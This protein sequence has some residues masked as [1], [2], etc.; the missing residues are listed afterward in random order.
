MRQLLTDPKKKNEATVELVCLR[1]VYPVRLASYYM[2]SISKVNVFE[3]REQLIT[4]VGL[5]LA[6]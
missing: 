3:Y 6:E 4:V 1:F 5:M 2:M